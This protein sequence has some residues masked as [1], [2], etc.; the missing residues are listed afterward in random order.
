MTDFLNSLS[1]WGRAIV[2][3][4]FVAVIVVLCLLSLRSGGKR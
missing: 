4:L 2:T 3:M 1:P